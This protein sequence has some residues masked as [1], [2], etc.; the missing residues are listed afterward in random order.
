MRRRHRLHPFGVVEDHENDVLIVKGIN[1]ETAS[2]PILPTPHLFEPRRPAKHQG[3]CERHRKLAEE[4]SDEDEVIY[5]QNDQPILDKV[6][7]I[8]EDICNQVYQTAEAT[9]SEKEN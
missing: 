5:V 7:L 4:E 2:I 8:L 3:L 1:G 6:D 9:E